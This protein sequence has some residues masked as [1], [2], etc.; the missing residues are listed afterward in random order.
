MIKSN[1]NLY[2]LYVNDFIT[3]SAFADY[4]GV[5]DGQAKSIIA[6]SKVMWLAENSKHRSY[7]TNN[8]K[9]LTPNYENMREINAGVF[10]KRHAANLLAEYSA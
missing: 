8:C 4:M 9:N 2:L 6:R 5:T 7:F 3:V 1:S 10:M